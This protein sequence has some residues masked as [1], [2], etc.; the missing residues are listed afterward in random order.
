MLT[1]ND[2]RQKFRIVP[3]QVSVTYYPMNPVRS[4]L[5]V[6]GARLKDIQNLAEIQAAGI[7]ATY[8]SKLWILPAANMG[9]ISPALGDR[10]DDGTNIWRVEGSQPGMIAG[11]QV[12]FKLV[13][14]QERAS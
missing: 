1:A 4:T 6:D 12:E 14:N 13:C 3:G 2:L 11:V 5:E 8:D 9:T 7:R 10:I